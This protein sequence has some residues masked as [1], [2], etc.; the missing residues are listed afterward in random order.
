MSFRLALILLILS[1]FIGILGVQAQNREDTR[2]YERFTAGGRGDNLVYYTVDLPDYPRFIRIINES[3]AVFDTLT[4]VPWNTQIVIVFMGVP[5]SG[6]P[7]IGRV[8]S[9]SQAYVTRRE[10]QTLFDTQICHMLVFNGWESDPLIESE[11]AKQLFYCA[12]MAMGAVSIADINTPSNAWWIGAS[13]EWA[14]AQV[15]PSQFPRAYYNLFDYRRDVTK[16]R[17]ENFYFWEFLASTQGYGNAQRVIEQIGLVKRGLFPINYGYTPVELLHNWAKALIN[18]RLPIAPTLDLNGIDI[19]AGKGGSLT[20][21]LQ[22][23]S[24]DYVALAGFEVDA[25]NIGFVK[26]SNSIQG[27]YAV[28]IQTGGAYKQ[29][30]DAVSFQ[31]CPSSPS[32]L[33]VISR[34]DFNSTLSHALTIEWG[35]TESNKPCKP[36]EN[37]TTNTT[38]ASCVVGT[39]QVVVYPVTSM[40]N[41]L[42]PSDVDTSNFTFT[43][44]EDG[45]VTVA[46]NILI[47]SAGNGITEI[48]VPFAGSYQ[49]LSSLSG[50]HIYDVQT[51]AV[52][53]QAGGSAVNNDGGQ[54]LDM[55]D[56]IYQNSPNLAPW[57]PNGVLTCDDT[58][59]SWQTVEGLGYFSLIRLP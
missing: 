28:S 35:Q 18:R 5:Y 4:A 55:T 2:P 50:N 7:V 3:I 31:F 58:T 9:P 20:T 19:P 26:I 22:P 56:I 8:L 51:F 48:H 12:Q 59:L 6:S 39:W 47:N 23:L 53:I 13:A 46:Y 33:L 41:G 27:Q 36:K 38:D 52:T 10:P 42:D 29:L 14:S 11:I 1:G 40:Q 37:P 16:N 30:E 34:A 15:Y 43:F 45:T 24:A 54:I 21:T 49:V 44:A 25:G 57:S 17:W 32:D